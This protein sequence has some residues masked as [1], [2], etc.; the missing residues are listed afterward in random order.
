MWKSLNPAAASPSPTDAA[1]KLFHDR[2]DSHTAIQAIIDDLSANITDDV[3]TR[4]Q[5]R[6]FRMNANRQKG[7]MARNAARVEDNFLELIFTEIAQYGLQVWCPDVLGSK[8]TSLYNSAHE[9]VAIHSFQRVASAG[10]YVFMSPSLQNINDKQLLIKLYRN[11]VFS[12]E[13]KKIISEDKVA[14]SVAVSK[15]NTDIYKRRQR[16]RSFTS[17]SLH[18]KT[19]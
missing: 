6:D 18:L 19:Y 7:S 10:G 3:D 17:S 14:G 13:G 1:L 5:I 12:T 4:T 8:P 15:G 9:L 16:V 11:F 2:F